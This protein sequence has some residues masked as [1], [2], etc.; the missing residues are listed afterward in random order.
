MEFVL[1]YLSN[2]NY[3]YYYIIIFSSFREISAASA[4]LV[5]MYKYFEL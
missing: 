2:N 5:Y 3:Y 1:I 4:R